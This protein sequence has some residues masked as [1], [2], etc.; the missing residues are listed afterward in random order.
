MQRSSFCLFLFPQNTWFCVIASVLLENQ[1]TEQFLLV[2]SYFPRML[3][4]V[5]LRQFCWW[6]I[7]NTAGFF[8]SYFCSRRTERTSQSALKHTSPCCLFSVGGQLGKVW[9]GGLI[10]AG[11]SPHAGLP[12]LH[13]CQYISAQLQLP[14]V[15]REVSASD[16][17]SSPIMS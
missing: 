5:S 8:P 14:D 15:E 4:F 10:G 11:C 12:H 7:Q 9:S 16:L 17:K 3:G 1:T 2:C 13:L 6:P